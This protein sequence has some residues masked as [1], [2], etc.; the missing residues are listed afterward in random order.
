MTVDPA[1]SRSVLDG[2]WADVRRDAREHLGDP[3]LPARSRAE[4]RGVPRARHHGEPRKLAESR[5]PSASASRRT[6]AS[7]DVGGVVTAFEM[8]GVR[9]PV[10]D[11]QGRRAVGPVRRRRP[12]AGHQ[13]H[14]D[15]YLRAI[16]SFELPGCFAMTETGHGSDV[17]QLRTTCHL[18]PGDAGV[19]PAHARPG[20]AQGLHRQRRPGRADGRR[21]RPADHRAARATAC[22]PGWCRSATR[23]ARRCPGV[24]IGDGGPKAG[25][26]RRRQRPADVRPRAGAAGECC[27]TATARSP[28]TAPTPAPSRTRPAASSRCSARWSAAGSAS[29]A[30]AGSATKM[31]LDIAVRY[32]D[33][34]PP[35]RRPRRRGEESSSTTTSSTSASCCPRWPPPTRCTSRRSELVSDDAR[36]PAA[37][38]EQAPDDGEDRSASWSPGPPGSRR[39]DLARHPHDPD[40][41]R[42]LRRRR[43][44]GGEPAARSSRPT[45]TSSPRSRATTPSCCSWSPR[46]CSRTTA[47]ASASS[48]WRARRGS[49]ADLVAGSVAE[50]TGPAGRRCGGGD[51]RDRSYQR[52]LLVEREEH[53]LA[54]RRAA[55]AAG[56]D[57]RE[58]TS[59]PSSTAPRT[60][61][62]WP[63][64]RTSTGSCST[65]SPPPSTG[66]AEPRRTRP[67]RPGVRAA[68]A[69]GDRGRPR[70]VRRARLPHRRAAPRRSPGR[71]TSCAGAASARPDAGRRLRHP[72]GLARL[73]AARRRAECGGPGNQPGPVPPRNPGIWRQ[74]ADP[75]QPAQR[76]NRTERTR[77]SC[78][79]SRA[80]ATRR[81]RT[82]GTAAR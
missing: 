1:N 4:H 11:G 37:V 82:N 62:S 35:V 70:L 20:R 24:T 59:S 41:P 76:S 23:T 8:L 34:P 63:R 71:S 13:R 6:A 9:R 40:V 26:Q 67:A 77:R 55:D 61:C 2:R 36:R 27:S 12:A 32:G 60:T 73:P 17:Q 44:P 46:R 48:T 30:A 21:V 80:P 69:V 14:H 51:V 75:E 42:G 74:W 56:T 81:R 52:W 31:A 3:A 72:G 57:A 50:R 54:A 15:E 49:R 79:W 16:M 10:A 66:C 68:R 65:P 19:R 47:G 38:R 64:G 7:D 33:D 43:L 53:L 45:P 22:T 18:R 58:P 39:S 5:P 29:R 25:P 78:N 28:R